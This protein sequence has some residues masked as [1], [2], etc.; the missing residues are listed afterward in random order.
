MSMSDYSIRD[1]C[2]VNTNFENDVFVGIKCEEGEFSVNFPLGFSVAEDDK[3]LRRDIILLM[4]TIASTTGKR[5]SEISEGNSK[6]SEEQF[7]FQSYIS[8]IYDFCS[9]GYYKER[10]VQYNVSKKGK[11]D[12]N[13][14]I[15]TQRPFIQNNE[16]FYLDFITKK[17]LINEN[18]MITLIHEY[19]VYEAFSKIGWLFT[20][21]M[22]ELPKIKFNK[23]IF[24][25]V[26]I[27][28]Y[29]HTF[30]DKNKALFKAMLEMVDYVGNDSAEKNYKYGTYRFEYVW[31][32][33]IDRAFGIKN[34]YDYYP[35]T[36]WT[37][38]GISYDTQEE[39]DNSSLRP[40]TIMLCNGNVYVLD[41]KYY[42]YGEMRAQGFLPKSTDINKQIT[43]G[44]YIAEQEKFKIIHGD[45]YKVF[46]AFLMP[47]NAKKN[48]AN[49]CMVNIGYACGNWKNNVKE[50]E[51]VHGILVD[52]KYLMKMGAGEEADQTIKLAECINTMM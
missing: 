19:C 20:S 51:K 50:Y 14:T 46:N 11:I 44:E 30:N 13:K 15:K 38:G 25:M 35:K 49:S 33:L 8:V 5:E 4:T 37:I 52:V 24:R 17:N 31:E 10:E 21:A 7:P 1:K 6:N 42:K 22:P 28:K 34:K 29:T 16:V 43:Y 3:E 23:R 45:N 32:T 41:A 48:G 36:S 47:F 27:D 26:L 40:D 9:R 2:R 39:F 18:E 12:W